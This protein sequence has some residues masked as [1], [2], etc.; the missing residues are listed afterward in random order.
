MLISELQINLFQ[1]PPVIFWIEREPEPR[2]SDTSQSFSQLLALHFYRL[3]WLKT[4]VLTTTFAIQHVLYFPAECFRHYIKSLKGLRCWYIRNA[5]H[6]EVVSTFFRA[7][8]KF[9]WCIK[10]RKTLVISHLFMMFSMHWQVQDLVL[11]Y[12]VF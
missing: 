11:L 2:S 10:H 7:T 6:T 9:N 3:P 1:L 8:A 5:E 12:F 4:S